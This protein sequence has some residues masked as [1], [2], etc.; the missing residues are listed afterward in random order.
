M[1]PNCGC[2]RKRRRQAS[3]PPRPKS[4]P[5]YKRPEHRSAQRSRRHERKSVPRNAPHNRNLEQRL[6]L[7][8]PESAPS[9]DLGQSDLVGSEASSELLATPFLEPSAPLAH[10]VAPHLVSADPLRLVAPCRRR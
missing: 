6:G 10:L 5:A 2:L 8:G 1:P 4:A 3:A 9:I 7:V